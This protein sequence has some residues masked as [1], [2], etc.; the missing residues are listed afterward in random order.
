MGEIIGL[1]DA[2]AAVQLTVKEVLSH[3]QIPSFATNLSGEKTYA[4]GDNASALTVSTTVTA[5]NVTYQWYENSKN[6]T[7][8]TAI[9]GAMTA[10]YTPK[11]D[12]AGVYYY[13]V[14]ATNTNNSVSGTKT[15]AATSDIYKVTV[16]NLEVLAPKV[17]ND[18]PKATLQDDSSKIKQAVITDGDKTKLA[19]GSDISIYLKVAKLDVPQAE[20]GLVLTV[21]D[22][23]TV[24]Q[25]LDISLIKNIDGNETKVAQTNSVIRITLVIPEDLRASG[26]AFGIIRVHNGVTTTL[27]DLDNDPNTIT[28][29]TDRFSTY[30]IIYANT[31]STGTTSKPVENKNTG[32]YSSI[33]LFA[34]LGLGS[35]TTALTVRKKRKY[36]V[37][38]KR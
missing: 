31:T 20:E 18:T 23:K 9:A 38:T 30:A 28:I 4:K 13:Y 34:M 17:S 14:V 27:P 5:G 7:T 32:D 37:I 1:G 3:A 15:A 19:N 2:P 29:E 12:K 25:Y 36:R 26:R 16:N 35:L 8:G 33:A 21:L 11:T 10:S 6:S 22:G 24:G